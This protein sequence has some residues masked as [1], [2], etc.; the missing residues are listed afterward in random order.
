MSKPVLAIIDSDE[1]YLVRLRDIINEKNL[2]PFTLSVFTQ[3]RKFRDY[4]NKCKVNFCL[5]SEDMKDHIRPEESIKVINLCEEEQDE[6]ENSIYRYRSV[7]Y[8]VERL[9][10]LTGVNVVK[11]N[12]GK[13]GKAGLIGIYS[14]IGRCLKTSFSLVLG[15]LL[16]VNNRVLYLNFE[17]YSGFS[18]LLGR[19][20]SPDMA[21]LL[22]YF[23]NLE[24]EF[25]DSFVKT[26]QTLN[27]MDFIPPAMSFMDITGITEE[28][29]LKFLGKIR[30]WE[31]Y[32][33]I[34]L[35]LSDYV[36]GL[37]HILRECG[38]VYMLEKTDGVAMAKIHQYEELLESLDF[39]DV[40]QKTVRCNAPVLKHLPAEAEKLVYSE[41][42]DFVRKTAKEDFDF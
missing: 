6:D 4:R 39:E 17:S 11:K 12:N 25:K 22:Y 3:P 18:Q 10:A 42:A 34:I 13:T 9:A 2:L 28:E 38:H 31:E 35:D 14:P 15:Q 30:E 33:Y 8:L 26:R 21:D 27:G 37:F 16:A 41:L 32:D 40:Y 20:M 7:D 23:K 1:E 24:G 5:V 19:E 29:W 36:Q